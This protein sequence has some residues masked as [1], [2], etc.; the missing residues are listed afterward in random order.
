MKLTFLFALASLAVACSGSTT[1][2]DSSPPAYD[3][4][5]SW[6]GTFISQTGVRGGTS[7]SFTQA[8]SSVGGSFT[9]NNSCIGGGKFAG[10]L[11]ADSLSGNV[12]A[13]AVSIA[14]SGTVSTVNQIDGTYTLSAAGGCPTDSGSFHLTR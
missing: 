7:A 9:A 3:V 11:S 8:G 10:T 14:M 1:S 12:T 2:V 6:S 4:S 5:G 13:G